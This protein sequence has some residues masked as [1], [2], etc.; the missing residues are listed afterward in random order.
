ML[1]IF[2]LGCYYVY[3]N[4]RRDKKALASG[5]TAEEQEREGEILGESDTTDLQN[6]HFR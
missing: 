5:R 2:L 6:P 3:T 1:D 4:R